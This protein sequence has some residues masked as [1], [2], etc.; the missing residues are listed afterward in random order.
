MDKL[1]RKK[2]S[3]REQQRQVQE[4]INAEVHKPINFAI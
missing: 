4:V 1:S 3:T 2:L